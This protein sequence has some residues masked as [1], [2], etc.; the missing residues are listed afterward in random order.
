[1]AEVPGV[2]YDAVGDPGAAACDVEVRAEDPV[3]DPAVGGAGLDLASSC[4]DRLAPGRWDRLRR[5][6]ANQNLHLVYYN[7]YILFR[8]SWFL[9]IVEEEKLRII[10]IYSLG[11]N[12]RS[13][14]LNLHPKDECKKLLLKY[15]YLV[16]RPPALRLILLCLNYC[17][18]LIF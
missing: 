11:G 9:T 15:I 3:E 7:V 4:A 12:K 8:T 6:L 5:N 10:K 13:H 2:A 16:I 1:M 14:L 18:V 17:P